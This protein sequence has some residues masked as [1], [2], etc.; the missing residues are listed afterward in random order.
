MDDERIKW[1]SRLEKCHPY[2]EKEY[3]QMGLRSL[4]YL[5]EKKLVELD[6]DPMDVLNSGESVK[7]VFLRYDDKSY[8]H[9][10]RLKAKLT[11]S[12]IDLIDK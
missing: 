5:H 3:P 7:D 9:V 6:V 8:A 11:A 12:G 2:N 10:Q 1:L 4:Y